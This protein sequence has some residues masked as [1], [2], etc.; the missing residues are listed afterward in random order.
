MF[1]PKSDIRKNH[2]SIFRN[3]TGVLNGIRVEVARES[4]SAA[5]V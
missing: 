4:V 2:E 5:T 1:M 3:S